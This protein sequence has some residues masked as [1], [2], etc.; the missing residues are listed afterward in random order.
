M[1]FY[2]PEAFYLLLLLIPVIV[3]YIYREKNNKT[4]V[5]FSNLSDVKKMKPS[6]AIWA[7]HLLILLKIAGFS[8]L[9]V[10]LAR[11]QKGSSFEEITT[12][13]V[14]IMVAMDIS[15][16]MAALDFKPD[17]RLEV[18]KRQMIEFIDRRNSDRIGLLIYAAR[19]I[20]LSPL[21]LDYDLLRQIIA[22]ISF[23]SLDEDGTAI[24]TAIATAANRLRTSQSPSRII[25]LL[26]DGANNRGEISPIMAARA[27]AELGIRI[28]TI[29]IGR[30]GMVPFPMRVRNPFTGAITT[31]ITMVESDV[32]VETLKIISEISGGSFFRAE[33]SE[34]LQEIYAIIDEMEKSTVESRIFTNYTDRFHLF[35]IWGFILLVLEFILRQTR[36]RRIP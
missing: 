15:G 9:I 22:N 1:R 25:I 27:A 10:A 13:G 18:A 6:F 34:E 7:R 30:E 16:S 17:N 8:L 21:T 29:A 4:A 28:H 20:T 35:L 33:N 24:G 32:D 19:A 14:D 3:F 23:D 12:Q 36:F 5:R 26:T 2:S 31:E 11:P